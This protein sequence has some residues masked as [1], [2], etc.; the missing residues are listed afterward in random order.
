MSGDLPSHQSIGTMDLCY[1][2]TW[3]DKQVVLYLVL[4]PVVA[5]A[6]AVIAIL[7]LIREQVD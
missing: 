7:E 4:W 6:N 2:K 5:V 3:P 1:S